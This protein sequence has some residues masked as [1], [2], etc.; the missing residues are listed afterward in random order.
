MTPK[1]YQRLIGRVGASL[2]NGRGGTINGRAG[3]YNAVSALANAHPGSDILLED[4]T[5]LLMEDGTSTF[6]LEV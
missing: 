2:A 1:I 6:L 5:F 4:G 3:P